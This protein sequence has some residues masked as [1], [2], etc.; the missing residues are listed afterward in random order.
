[1][2]L[3]IKVP[4]TELYNPKTNEFINLPEKTLV[5]EHSL[6]SIS[7]WESK[8]HISYVDTKEKTQEQMLD[9]ISCMSLK[10][11]IP[12]EVISSLTEQNIREITN[13]I[14]DPMTASTIK[15]T[16]KP[17]GKQQIITSELIYSW[18]VA[19]QIP[20]EFEKWH[21][22][23]L[24]ILIEIISEQNKAPSKMSKAETMRRYKDINAKNR[25]KYHSKG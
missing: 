25:A 5:L 2:P 23:R 18:M 9:Y 3:T 7:K 10:G 19:Y 13:Y 6:I 1:M 22:N 14:S 4:G 15:R 20:V 17:G 24:L 21:L 16:S 11:D 8:W 12:F